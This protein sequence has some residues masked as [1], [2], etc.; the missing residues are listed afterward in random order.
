MFWGVNVVYLCPWEGKDKEEELGREEGKRAW[1][2]RTSASLTRVRE[3]VGPP[4][5]EPVSSLRRDHDKFHPHLSK[6]TLTTSMKS[7]WFICPQLNVPQGILNNWN[8]F[9]FSQSRKM[10][11]NVSPLVIK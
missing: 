10:M 5:P 9:L 6:W 2:A 7:P 4:G 3:G 1:E 11:L 8:V